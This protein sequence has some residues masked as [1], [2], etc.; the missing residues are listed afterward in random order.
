MMCARFP[1]D[2]DRIEPDVKVLLVAHPRDISDVAQYAI[3]QFVLR[4][5]KLIA[6]LDSYAYFDQ[7]RNP[8]NL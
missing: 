2:A 3:D 5:G 8:T 7:V 1:L 6:F 4:G